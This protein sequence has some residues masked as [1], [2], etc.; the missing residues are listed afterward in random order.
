MEP[1]GIG[2]SLMNNDDT[3]IINYTP[4]S[5]DHYTVIV[6]L[7]EYWDEI[8]D[9]IINENEI[10]GIPN[11]RISCLNS[12]VYSLRSAIYEMSQAE[13]DVLKNHPKVE[14]V[15]LSRE[16][17]PQQVSHMTQRYRKDVA[18]QKPFCPGDKGDLTSM[19]HQNGKRSNWSHLFVSDPSSKPFK[20]VGITTISNA[21][22]VDDR[23]Y[24]LDGAGV[25]AVILD[26]GCH[27]LHP[28]FID[29]ETGAYRA[30]DMILD[31]PYY[32]DPDYFTT[33]NY[34]Y[35]KVIDGV[36][37]GVGIDTT[38]AHLWWT[39]AS[40][41]SAAF[42]NLGSISSIDSRYTMGHAQSKTSNSNSNQ[43]TGGHGTACCSQVG[44]KTFGLAFKCNIWS[45]RINFGA[46]YMDAGPSIDI[47]TIF[48]NAKKLKSDDPDPTITSNSYVYT[49]SCGNSSGVTYTHTYRG[50]TMTYTGTGTVWTAATNAG[51]CGNRSLYSY[52]TGSTATYSGYSNIGNYDSGLRYGA[53]ANVAT[54]SA[55][56]AGVIMIV[57]AGNNNQ[58]LCDSKDPDYNN[59]IVT[60]GT[61][62]YV[63]RVG[64]IN[65]GHSNPDDSREMGSIRVGAL[66]CGVEP[67]DLKQGV[68]AFSI[69]KTAYS[70]CGPMI[71]IWAPAQDTMSAGYAAY[72][73]SGMEREDDSDFYDYFFAGT[74]SA[75][76][77][78]ASVV[79]LYLSTNR[80]ANQADVFKW[81]DTHGSKEIALSDPY[82]DDSTV[83]YWNGAGLASP[84]YPF[85]AAAAKQYDSYNC[86]GCGNLRGAT[87][88]VL[89][90]PYA[91]NRKPSV[92]G[93][94][95]TVKGV[96]FKQT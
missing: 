48:H 80:K 14:T 46:A 21:R 92:K 67:D 43:M 55:I 58:K 86:V 62:H 81:L 71:S 94:R 37:V 75:C 77:N 15:E 5:I 69:R 12:K 78:C 30:R 73:A 6:E 26:D 65:K 57:S 96:S 53:T 91:N 35:T 11:R 10:D 32:I 2:S 87:K 76:P 88:K 41:R 39:N 34:T 95:V 42:Q 29:E 72:E 79:A 52:N 27:P 60:S 16:K 70:A 36:T 24:S 83:H 68:P 19:T 89:H 3:P 50:S 61:H 9:Y 23:P 45:I 31:G 66:D 63:N 1:I 4:E 82:P 33:N 74:S 7:P 85:N 40:N 64:S 44:G 38:R 56:A 84:D 49:S 51:S 22:Y 90:N 93:D 18:F 59:T 8:H 25:D 28:E 17:Y 54:E 13:A 20:G 47:C